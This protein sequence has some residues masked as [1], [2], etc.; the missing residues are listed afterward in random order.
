MAAKGFEVLKNFLFAFDRIGIN[1]AHS[2]TGY[3]ELK[4][5]LFDRSIS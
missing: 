4:N 5:F 3:F 2:S 1:Q